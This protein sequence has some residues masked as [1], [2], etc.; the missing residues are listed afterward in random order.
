MGNSTH[1]VEVLRLESIQ[2]HPNADRLGIAS[3]YGYTVCVGLEE[4][5]EGDL[6]AYIPPDS[7]VPETEQFAFLADHRRIKVKKLRGIISQG[8]LILAPPGSKEGD[9]VAG[10]L[11]ITHYVPPEPLTMG[12]ETEHPPNGYFPFYDV[13]SFYRY[14]DLLQ[15]GE[16][17]VVSEKIHGCSGR[18]VWQDGRLHCGSRAEWKRED[19]NNLW[20]KAATQNRWIIDFCKD[21]EDIAVYGEVYGNV[22]DLKYGV[23]ANTFRVAVF[24]LLRGDQWVPYEEARDIGT[25]LLWVPELYR[26]PYDAQAVIALAE[27]YST[28]PGADNVREGCVIKPLKERTDPTIGRVQLKIASNQYLERA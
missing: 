3:I 10:L 25:A 1:R 23:T 11:G 5:K 13:E 9:D 27:G 4:F 16:Q 14:S 22:Q 7:I 17:V 21:H 20:W 12:G 8:L 26:G 2:K 15:V 6:V 19:T 28:I 24:D 18:F